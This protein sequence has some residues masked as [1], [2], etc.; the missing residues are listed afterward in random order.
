MQV[1]LAMG[2]TMA[3]VEVKFPML[4]AARAMYKYHR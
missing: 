3:R 2:K 4:N 1:V